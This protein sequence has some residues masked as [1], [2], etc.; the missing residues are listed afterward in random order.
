[1]NFLNESGIKT[2]GM[3]I[4]DGSGLSPLNAINASGIGQFTVTI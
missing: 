3:F 4:E 2:D 1:M